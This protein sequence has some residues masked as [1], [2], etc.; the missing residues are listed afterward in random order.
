MTGVGFLEAVAANER[1]AGLK[2]VLVT[3]MSWTGDIAEVRRLGGHALLTKPV[4]EAELIATV[5][6][7]LGVPVRNNLESAAN[8]SKRRARDIAIKARVLVAEDNPIN[9]EVASEL[10]SAFGCEVRVAKDGLEAVMLFKSETFDVILMDCQMPGMDGP[11]ATRH[12]R[13]R[14]REAGLRSIPI[15]AVTAHAYDE[16]RRACLAAGMDDYLS[17]PYSET[18]LKEIQ[19]Q[20]LRDGQIIFDDQCLF[21]FYKIINLLIHV[22]HLFQKKQK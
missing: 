13:T 12:I 20:K 17:K 5:S 8:I 18:Q 11:A 7:A 2:T 16:D 19:F 21:G 3:S 15:I 1:S 22:L 6:S 4:R 10:L 14:E 9:I